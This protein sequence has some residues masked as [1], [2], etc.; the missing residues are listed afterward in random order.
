M[1][2]TADEICAGS[3]E[4]LSQ[5][6]LEPL[7]R[8]LLDK[9]NFRRAK[10]KMLSSRLEACSYAATTAEDQA[11]TLGERHGDTENAVG[12]NLRAQTTNGGRFV[13]RMFARALAEMPEIIVAR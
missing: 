3:R 13:D 12:E 5:A 1:P 8:R 7:H 6:E 9:S 4:F 10:R 11:V 2:A